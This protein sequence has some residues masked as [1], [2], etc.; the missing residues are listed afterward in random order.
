MNKLD[1]RH[2][3]PPLTRHISPYKPILD[4]TFCHIPL[5][6]FFEKT[7]KSMILKLLAVF[8]PSE[9]WIFRKKIFWKIRH[10]SPPFTRHISPYNPILDKTFHHISPLFTRHISP[11]RVIILRKNYSEKHNILQKH[12]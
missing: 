1:F 2:I 8:Y 11:Y 9:L 4:K 5:P 3:S 10:I 6:Y 7:I 12:E